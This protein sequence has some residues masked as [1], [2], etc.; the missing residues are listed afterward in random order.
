MPRWDVIRNQSFEPRNDAVLKFFYRIFQSIHAMLGLD[1]F[2]SL[3]HPATDDHRATPATPAEAVATS[4]L[5]A[6]AAKRVKSLVEPRLPSFVLYRVDKNVRW[7]ASSHL[8]AA[9]SFCGDKALFGIDVVRQYSR[10]TARGAA[11][12]AHIVGFWLWITDGVKEGASSSNAPGETGVLA[13]SN[14][15]LS[16]VSAIS[17]PTSSPSPPHDATSPDSMSR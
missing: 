17:S 15:I 5:V 12:E 9:A 4:V 11:Y 14:P 16:S 7:A 1:L 6:K 3:R 8:G 13:I 10:S 2:K